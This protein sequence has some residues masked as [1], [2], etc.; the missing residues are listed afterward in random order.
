MIF[1]FYLAINKIMSIK[2][3]THLRISGTGR[4]D[5]SGERV[6]KDTFAN[7]EI[8]KSDNSS[9]SHANPLFNRQKPFLAQVKSKIPNGEK[10]ASSFY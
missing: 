8:Q 7:P 10:E 1:N 2:K 3:D 4:C 9:I 6:K 5:T